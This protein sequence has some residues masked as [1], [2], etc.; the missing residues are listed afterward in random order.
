[1]RKVRIRLTH[2]TLKESIGMSNTIET[3]KFV[4]RK[5]ELFSYFQWTNIMFDR[6]HV[7]FRTV[8]KRTLNHNTTATKLPITLEIKT[9]LF[10]QR[11]VQL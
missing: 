1:M 3:I 10:S 4:D 6:G 2:R 5:F 9:E 8:F 7:F 11:A